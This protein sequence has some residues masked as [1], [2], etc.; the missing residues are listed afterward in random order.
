MSPPQTPSAGLESKTRKKQFLSCRVSR[1][2]VKFYGCDD[3]EKKLLIEK[4]AY[5]EPNI[6]IKDL[7][8]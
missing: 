4:Y 3:E 6:R 7:H 2:A 8:S 1:F 5:P